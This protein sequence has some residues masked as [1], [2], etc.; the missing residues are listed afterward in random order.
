MGCQFR[1]CRFD[2]CGRRSLHLVR[3]DSCVRTILFAEFHEKGVQSV[4]RGSSASRSPSPRNVNARVMDA[5]A[6]LGPR[7]I[8]SWA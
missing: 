6:R 5:I 3:N 8:H 2:R 1:N 7:S 4:C